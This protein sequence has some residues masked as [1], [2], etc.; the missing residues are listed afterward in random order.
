[1]QPGVSGVYTEQGLLQSYPFCLPTMT[2]QFDRL[3]SLPESESTSE[4]KHP[5]E[6]GT[7]SF[8]G[9]AGPDS[10]HKLRSCKFR[11]ECDKNANPP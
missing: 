7:R 1:M 6:T 5:V 4:F 2:V 8:P 10:L 3:K 11:Q 9:L